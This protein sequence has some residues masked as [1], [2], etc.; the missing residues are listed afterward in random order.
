MRIAKIAGLILL[1]AFFA[2]QHYPESA[3]Y[4]RLNLVG[5][6]PSDF[7]EAIIFSTNPILESGVIINVDTDQ[8]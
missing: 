8:E 2:F 6:L 4:I 7:K 1:F 5:Y 3:V